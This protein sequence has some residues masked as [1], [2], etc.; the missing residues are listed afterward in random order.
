MNS[1]DFPRQ[2]AQTRR[3]TAGRPRSFTVAPSGRHV[4]FLRSSRG[5]DPVNSLWH[6]DL[7]DVSETC[8]VDPRSL[9]AGDEDA[10]LPP[11]ERSRRERAREMSA[12][13]VRYASDRDVT[14]A[15]FA[16]D[17]RTFRVDTADGAVVEMPLPDGAFDARPDPA[18]RRVAFVHGGTLHV[19]DGDEVRTLVDEGGDDV[20]WGE[21]EFV[22]AEEM[23]RTRGFWWSPDGERL[24]VARVD[25]GHVASW[26][27][28]DP[29]RPELPPSSVR[30]PHAGSSNADVTL[31]LV[32]L[33]G[34]RRQ[35]TW[36]RQDLPYL[37]TV[38]W[39]R[40][41]P[42]T[43][44]VQS[45]D[46]RRLVVV[47]VDPQD[48][49]TE[50]V[51]EIT[52][53]RWVDLVPGA[54][55]WL[56]GGLLTVEVDADVDTSRLHLDGEPVTPPGMQVRAILHADDDAAWVSASTDPLDV[57]VYRV[58]RDGVPERHVTAPGVHGAAVEGDVTVTVAAT[59]EQPP[60]VT[61]Q[62]A[63]TDVATIASM[64]EDP[65]VSPAPRFLD[66][67]TSSLRAA[68]L[69]PTH[70]E[71]GTLP[72]LVSPYGGP[73][74][75]RVLHARDH[76]L[77]SQWFADQGFAVLVVDG[78][79]TPGRG[80]AWERAVHRDLAQPVLEDQ[81]IALREAAAI[82]RRLDLGRV[83]IR[84]WSFGGF[85]A[86]LAVIR[87]P[88]VFHAAVAGAPVADWRLYDT[89]Y[90][91]RYLGLPDADPDAYRR[92]SLVDEHGQLVDASEPPHD[93]H[94][95]LLIVHGLAD[96]NVVAAHSLRLSHALLAAG[97]PHAFLPLSG[98]THMTPQ[99][100]ISEN[101]LRLELD[102]LRGALGNYS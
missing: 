79:G 71:G 4:L 53:R 58:T 10:E 72:V 52:D 89:H 84:G 43:L 41:A 9:P 77:V 32:G 15:L 39:D 66:L 68:L 65:V 5:D 90:T 20:S 46:Q 73:H 75:Q 78:R 99:T 48:G 26:T 47:K 83:G 30:Y 8:L 1:S 98:V 16:L 91:E 80:P 14:V 42:P 25:V 102:F 23:G 62:R 92:S 38:A 50:P 87:R 12:G 35:V 60:T 94:P 17:G 29:A 93:R 22:A 28:A 56:D 54:P 27:I 21:A 76:H 6:L 51:R 34:S 61:V 63:G 49:A 33:D 11:E 57:G 55:A 74:A 96:D 86:A 24:L 101:L 95:A 18:G 64:G 13:I 40:S 2:L 45:R 88:D 81:V 37:A 100:V 67:G 36:D 70:D 85:L 97:R 82:E 31:W 19:L 7:E 69:L 44:S 3:F 59:L